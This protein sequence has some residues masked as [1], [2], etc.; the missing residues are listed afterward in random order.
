MVFASFEKKLAMDREP[1]HKTT[2]GKM[3]RKRMQN[4][5]EEITQIYMYIY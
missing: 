1:E 4:V 2:T 5:N 3:S